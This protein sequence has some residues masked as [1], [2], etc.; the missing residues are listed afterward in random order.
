MKF[1]TALHEAKYDSRLDWVD[2]AKGTGIIL[3]VFGHLTYAPQ[4]A[5]VHFLGE[6]DE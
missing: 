3:V 6:D 1:Q 4:G 5:W 2:V